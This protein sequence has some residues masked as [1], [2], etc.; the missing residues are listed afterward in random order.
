MSPALG[1][2]G[3]PS[4][5]PRPRVWTVQPRDTFSN[6]SDPSPSAQEKVRP[7]Q[8]M[9]GHSPGSKKVLPCT[10]VACVC[11]CV[12]VA[13][14]PGPTHSHLHTHTS[15]ELPLYKLPSMILYHQFN[16]S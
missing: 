8:D 3:G 10:A 9:V 4:E 2:P 11:V 5:Q 15:L 14:I 1:R 6:G 7:G 13:Y 16:M 12:C